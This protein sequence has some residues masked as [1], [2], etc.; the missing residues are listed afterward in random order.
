MKN[1]EQQLTTMDSNGQQWTT[2]HNNGQQWMKISAVLLAPLMPFS[3][4]WRIP[5]QT[6]PTLD[7]CAKCCPIGIA[8]V[9]NLWASRYLPFWNARLVSSRGDE[10]HICDIWSPIPHGSGT[11][12]TE[13]NISVT[14]RISNEDPAAA[15]GLLI[16]YC[17][18]FQTMYNNG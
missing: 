12:A 15:G 4:W 17:N 6:F 13:P 2:M 8:N 5:N 7:M 18:S 14:D 1:N 11:A 9:R 10:G 3:P 16:I